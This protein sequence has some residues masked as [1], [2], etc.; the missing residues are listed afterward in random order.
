[1]DKILILLF[2][3][4][5]L[6]IVRHGYYL[7]QTIIFNANNTDEGLEPLKYKLSEKALILLGLSISYVL[8]ALVTIF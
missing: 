6:N 7:L 4:A 1:M 5:I 2:F 3:L 8:T